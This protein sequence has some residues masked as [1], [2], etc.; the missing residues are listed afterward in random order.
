MESCRT[1]DLQ[2][3]AFLLATGHAIRGVEGP[4]ER[5]VF[6]FESVPDGAIASYYRGDR[7]VSPQPLFHAYRELK[8]RL[9][10]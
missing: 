4:P 5:R 1:S 3:A 9:F 10:G 2:L 6:V 7:P 8:R